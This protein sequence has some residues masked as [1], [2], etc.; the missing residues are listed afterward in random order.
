MRDNFVSTLK[1]GMVIFIPYW[2]YGS[3][4]KSPFLLLFWL[5]PQRR[6]CCSRT[7]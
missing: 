4:R 1:Q 2:I 5:T 6:L 7:G 3:Q